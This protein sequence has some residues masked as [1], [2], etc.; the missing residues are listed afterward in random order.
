M[1]QTGKF[2]SWSNL[3]RQW[4][5]LFS[6]PSGQCQ[7]Y[8]GC[9][10][11]SSCNAKNNPDACK[12]L[13]GFNRQRQINFGESSK[14]CA[15]KSDSCETKDITF[16]NLTKVKVRSP[17]KEVPA[18]SEAECKSV[19]L[20][21]CPPCQ[22]YSYDA[23]WSNRLH[24][25]CTIWTQDLLTLQEDAGQ[26]S[27]IS[28]SVRLLISD[29]APTA[30]TCEPCGTTVIPYPLSTGQNC[31]D[32]LYFWLNCDTSE[33]T[34]EVRFI[35]RKLGPKRVTEIDPGDRKLRTKLKIQTSVITKVKEFS[36]SHHLM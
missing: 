29:I 34:G 8:N 11:F 3:Q 9:G 13:P 4:V 31:G 12:C 16:L 5:L 21:T 24:P 10:N 20:N 26:N 28:L 14:V 30:K 2:E 18:G 15:R 33:A 17:G 23:R 1:N 22:A 35:M 7:M 32:P 19:C 36:S 27:S 25:A 6:Q